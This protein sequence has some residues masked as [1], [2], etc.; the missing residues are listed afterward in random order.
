[1]NESA[2]GAASDRLREL[3]RVLEHDPDAFDARAERAGLCASRAVSRTP[4]A[5]IWI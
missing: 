5:I 2:P 3:D 1:M 4:S